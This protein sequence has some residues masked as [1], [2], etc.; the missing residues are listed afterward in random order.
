VAVVPHAPDPATAP[1]NGGAAV[2]DRIELLEREAAL[3]GLA[4]ALRDAAHGH[5]RIVLVHGEAGIG[6]TALVDCF[7]A[8]HRG[9]ARVLVGRCD[10]LFTP[11]PLGPL[12]DVALQTG[13]DLL[14]LMES[15]ADRF[16]I[17][18]RLL[19]ELQGGGTPTILAFEDVHWADAATLDLLKY[20]G[21]RLDGAATLMLLTYRDDEL[22]ASHPL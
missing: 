9:E 8:A 10:A 22:N 7:L 4:D 6:K 21:R 5:G 17:F 20:L 19:H 15:A 2:V 18:G 1:A 11:R 12:H 3:A 14:Q 16:A 13:G